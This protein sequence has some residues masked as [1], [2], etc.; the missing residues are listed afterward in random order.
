MRELAVV[1][2]WTSAGLLAAGQF[3]DTRHARLIYLAAA[4]LF[5][6]G[7][8]LALGTW[9]WWRSAK[10]EHPSLGPLE[11]MGTRRWRRSDFTERTRR[12]DA[13]RPLPSDA[14]A[15]V[16]PELVDLDGVLNREHPH[17][18]GDLL[19]TADPTGGTVVEGDDLDAVDV[20]ALVAVEVVDP[21]PV[22]VAVDVEPEVAEPSLERVAVMRSIVIDTSPKPSDDAAEAPLVDPTAGAPIDPLLRLWSE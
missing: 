10:A 17:D 20:E 16:V 11:V 8:A 5:V 7:V 15:P 2:E 3:T 12:L 1:S 6:V 18:F 14:A 4:G 9:W 21:A 22:E 13:V 19:E